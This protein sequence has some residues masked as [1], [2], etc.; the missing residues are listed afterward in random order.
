MDCCYALG[1]LDCGFWA[2]SANPIERLGHIDVPIFFCH[3]Q[4]DELVPF[5]EGL[6]LFAS[7]D[8]P[9]G[10]WWVEGASHYNVRQRNH[11]EYL[12]RLRGFLDDC[13]S[14]S[15]CACSDGV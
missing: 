15:G 9:K 4:A 2:P 11:E 10:H 13:L 7:H 3:A 6:A 1:W 12:R 5:S 8:G 14:R